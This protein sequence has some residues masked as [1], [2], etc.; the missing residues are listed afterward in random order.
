MK[1]VGKIPQVRSGPYRSE[2]N[3]SNYLSIGVDAKAALLWARMAERIPWAF[4]LRMINKWWYII[5]GSPEFLLHSY[6]EAGRAFG[7]DM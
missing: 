1:I 7:A 4:K 3:F 5:C 6:E 2:L